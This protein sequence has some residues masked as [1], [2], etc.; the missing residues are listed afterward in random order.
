MVK[1]RIKIL[2]LFSF[3]FIFPGCFED[4]PA[5]SQTEGNT[6]GISAEEPAEDPEGAAET[7]ND[8]ELNPSSPAEDSPGVAP[9][10][11]SVEPETSCVLS[12]YFVYVSNRDFNNPE[13]DQA[14]SGDN[15]NVW[16]G[17]FDGPHYPLTQFVNAAITGPVA[18]FEEGTLVVYFVSDGNLNGQDLKGFF[19]TENI[20]KLTIEDFATSLAA[21]FENMPAPEPVTQMTAMLAHSSSPRISP[22]GTKVLYQSRRPLDGSNGVA[23][24]SWNLWFLNVAYAQHQPLPTTERAIQPLWSYDGEKIY[25]N[26]TRHPDPLNSGSY[27]WNIFWLSMLDPPLMLTNTGY[28]NGTIQYRHPRPN[29]AN[30]L[31]AY[32]SDR[33]LGEGESQIPNAGGAYN[34]WLTELD[35]SGFPADSSPFTTSLVADSRQV[36]WN[37]TGATFIFHSKI[38]PLDQTLEN[39][40]IDGAHYFNLWRGVLADGTFAPLTQLHESESTNPVFFNEN[41]QILF[42]S[43]RALD[44][45]DALN[46]GGNQNI[47]IMNSDGTEP[48]FV[49]DLTQ[50]DAHILIWNTVFDT[51]ICSE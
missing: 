25:Y 40:A 17:S 13:N 10:V 16:L 20:W 22:D 34:I 47:M 29:P 35:P 7:Q 14:N 30:T 4:D 12:T 1:K 44:G 19:E 23:T 27:G 39:T 32:H 5:S 36:H 42:N 31:V 37:P 9:V 48:S 26:S 51:E 8:S 45:T 3:F 50:A 41:Q 24:S 15:T 38:D 49:T 28:Q 6:E 11:A 2:L 21:G 46:T 18:F 43:T 33:G